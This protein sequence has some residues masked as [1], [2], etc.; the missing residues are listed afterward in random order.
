V[1]R[2]LWRDLRA[3]RYGHGGE[4]DAGGWPGLRQVVCVR[5]T[6]EYLERPDKPPTVEDHYYLTSRRPDRPEGSPEALL[7][8][9]RQHWSIENG[10]HHPKDRTMREDDQTTRRGAGLY[11]RLRSLVL[12]LLPYVDGASTALRQI[13]VQG[14]LGR[15]IGLLER[16]RFPKIRKCHF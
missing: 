9:A 14:D 7:A 8:L 4:G 6:R 5:T 10:L 12:G 16:K 13:A 11:A 3:S 15:A 2:E 1:T